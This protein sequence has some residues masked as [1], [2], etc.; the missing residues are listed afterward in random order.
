M[1]LNELRKMALSPVGASSA[2]G[3]V[4]NTDPSVHLVMAYY[5]KVDDTSNITYASMKVKASIEGTNL[6]LVPIQSR[7]PSAP[8]RAPDA[9]PP[10][11]GP[12]DVDTSLMDSLPPTR[13]FDETINLGTITFAIVKQNDP[14]YKSVR[15]ATLTG[16]TGVFLQYRIDY[17]PRSVFLVALDA[18]TTWSEF[19]KA[20]VYYVPGK[21]LCSAFTKDGAC[22]LYRTMPLDGTET[23]YSHPYLVGATGLAP[24]FCVTA[25]DLSDTMNTPQTKWHARSV[26]PVAWADLRAVVVLTGA[27]GLKMAMETKLQVH[28]W[29][30]VLLFTDAS[31]G[32]G[33]ASDV[34]AVHVFTF[35]KSSLE[36]L[37]AL[38][39]IT[40]RVVGVPT[41]TLPFSFRVLADLATR[42]FT[43]G[44]AVIAAG[45]CPIVVKP[46]DDT[47]VEPV[48]PQP[49][50]SRIPRRRIVEEVEDDTTPTAGSGEGAG[51]GAGTNAPKETSTSTG[52][53]V[54]VVL[55]PSVAEIREY[56]PTSDSDYDEDDFQ[57][58]RA[59][60]RR[61]EKEDVSFVDGRKIPASEL[62]AINERRLAFKTNPIQLFVTHTMGALP[63]DYRPVPSDALSRDLDVWNS[64]IISRTTQLLSSAHTRDLG[65]PKT[66]TAHKLPAYTDTDGDHDTFTVVLDRLL[67]K[68]GLFTTLFYALTALT[69][70]YTTLTT[71][72]ASSEKTKGC[73]QTFNIACKLFAAFQL[74]WHQQATPLSKRAT[75]KT[76]EEHLLTGIMVGAYAIA[77]YI[78]NE[79]SRADLIAAKYNSDHLRAQIKIAETI[80]SGVNASADTG[81]GASAGEG[82]GASA[83]AGSAAGAGASASAS[84]SAGAGAG[85]GA[86]SATGASTGASSSSSLDKT[87][88]L[89]DDLSIVLNSRKGHTVRERGPSTGASIEAPKPKVDLPSINNF[90]CVFVELGQTLNNNT[91]NTVGDVQQWRSFTETVRP[92]AEITG[93]AETCASLQYTGERIV[94]RHL[95]CI[96]AGTPKSEA[97]KTALLTALSDHIEAAN[98]ASS[99]VRDHNALRVRAQ[100][101]RSDAAKRATD[102]VWKSQ[103]EHASLMTE[104][105]RATVSPEKRAE[106]KTELTT[107]IVTLK[108]HE[109]AALDA[110]TRLSSLEEAGTERIQTATS[111]LNYIRNKIE[112]LTGAV[113]HC[114][115]AWTLP[116]INPEPEFVDTYE[117]PEFLAKLKTL[118]SERDVKK[119]ALDAKRKKH[120][121]AMGVTGLAS[122]IGA[123][124]LTDYQ[125]ALCFAFRSSISTEV[126]TAEDLKHATANPF[127]LLLLAVSNIQVPV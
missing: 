127:E 3:R 112:S 36:Q 61:L 45:M 92:V 99:A 90:L 81:A 63:W 7:T 8:E 55:E 96:R 40:S 32:S 79:F 19:V 26:A 119:A 111:N 9:V 75:A 105:R 49:K 108:K 34:P 85:A 41:A 54:T 117:T 11:S 115:A 37:R 44:G 20:I 58:D 106:I 118:V 67:A 48:Q 80:K 97:A 93:M 62:A 24:C 72:A 30:W 74:E 18:K 28:L 31:D 95:D 16:A 69:L 42:H 110:Q 84:A 51:A 123:I 23:A 122:A 5:P 124:E 70:T 104:R 22:M 71:G 29:T 43:F 56:D 15:G 120:V 59:A 13:T 113:K 73:K 109:A 82:A 25:K 60:A 91:V 53:G 88:I 39:W 2:P 21:Y 98:A 50:P 46:K 64:I 125:V 116:T 78:L 101:V 94:R 4:R 38:L 27:R 100:V 114:D 65:A 12:P 57:R 47:P 102:K 52:K 10:T 6:R 66:Y 103:E 77:N 35:A 1:A 14:E 89:I 83:G 86:G 87:D 126:F 33:A 107:A 76:S 121:K 68:H 17:Q